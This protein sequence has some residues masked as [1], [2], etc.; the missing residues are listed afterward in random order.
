MEH[1]EIKLQYY[2]LVCPI[3]MQLHYVIAVADKYVTKM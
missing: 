2:H 1:N 3:K